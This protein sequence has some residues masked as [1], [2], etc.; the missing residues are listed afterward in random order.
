[1]PPDTDEPPTISFADPPPSPPGD[2]KAKPPPSP[3]E[4]SPWVKLIMG[5]LTFRDS[6]GKTQ[7]CMFQFNPTELERSRT[8]KF[9]RTP[10]G[11]VLEEPD[12]GPRNQAKRKHTRKPDP[13]EITL[14]L[15]YDAAYYPHA[16][17]GPAKTYP[18]RI[19]QINDAMRFFEALAE[20]GL[21]VS[22]NESTANAH[23]TPPPPLLM[24]NYGRRAWQCAVKTL[25][26]KELD[27][28]RDLYLRRFE[29]T[30]ALEALETVQQSDTGKTGANRGAKS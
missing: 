14:T 8:V 23:E 26:I 18:E 9:T 11:N 20:P 27:Y 13:W 25:R 6:N 10:T 24:L 28:T 29:V 2:K 30:L 12:V 22:E 19:Q 3:P 15:R 21:R 16:D 7:R 5:S 1:M 17:P 4:L